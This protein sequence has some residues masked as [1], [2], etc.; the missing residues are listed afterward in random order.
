MAKAANASITVRG[1]ANRNTVI[2]IDAATATILKKE[3]YLKYVCRNDE[4]VRLT[5]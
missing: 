1:E 5:I 2:V 3:T 4:I